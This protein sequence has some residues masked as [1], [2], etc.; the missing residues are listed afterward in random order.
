MTSHLTA[1]DTHMMAIALMMA[2]RGLGRT[3]PNPAVGAVIADEATGEV[4]ARA[5]TAP[6]GRP[7][8]ETIAIAA[9]GEKARGKT[10]YVTLEPCSHQGLTGPCA[11]AIITAGLQ[12]AV[13]GIEDP[14]PRV[15]GRGLDML[16]KAGLEVQ[17]GVLAQDARWVTRGHIVRV[18]ERRPFVTLKMALD[19][20]GHVP[21]GTGQAPV[22]VTS[23]EAR[24]HG[25]L[26]RAK[27]DAILV[28]SGTVKADNPDL[29]CRL[30]G[31]EDRSPIRVVLA[32]DLEVPLHCKLVQSAREVPVWCVAGPDADPKRRAA[33]EAAGAEVITATVVGG[34]LW[35]PAVMEE[36][37]ARGITRLLVE[38]GPKI[39]RAFADAA[40]VDEVVLFQAGKP[41]AKEEWPVPTSLS[42]YLGALDVTPK[43]QTRV[44]PDSLWRFA[45]LTST[46]GR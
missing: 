35:L 29:T 7:H 41:P 4:I 15:A 8:A 38:G 6:G 34:K 19:A 11:D 44:G 9:A 21:R 3:A 23:P 27:A 24:A 31:L 22:F 45:R 25:H 28:G 20:G 32:R 37:V 43:A 12:R 10:I 46:E 30:P 2:R 13:V 33:L 42:G 16:R 17:R 14:D 40:L 18:T 26:L 39:W 5:T 1:F 36:L